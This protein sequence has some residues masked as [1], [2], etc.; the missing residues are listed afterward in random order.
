MRYVIFDTD[1]ST[2]HKTL[3]ICHDYSTYSLTFLITLKEEI[4]AGRKSRESREKFFRDFK[5]KSRVD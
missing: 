4:V 3:P 2:L 5:T 1:L